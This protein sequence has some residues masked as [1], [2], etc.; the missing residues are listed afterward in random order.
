MGSGE[1][2]RVGLTEY[3]PHLLFEWWIGPGAIS[4]TETTTLTSNP[5]SLEGI[6][7]SQLLPASPKASACIISQGFCLHLLTSSA[8]V[9]LLQFP[10]LELS[11]DL[12][13][14]HSHISHPKSWFSGTKPSSALGFPFILRTRL[15]KVCEGT[16]CYLRP[17]TTGPPDPLQHWLHPALDNLRI[18]LQFPGQN[19]L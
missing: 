1:G 13:S 18:I 9:L 12:S 4:S 16:P 15:P 17:C 14:P 6:N 7:P 2:A 10:D 11:G 8:L 3:P 5:T 19:S